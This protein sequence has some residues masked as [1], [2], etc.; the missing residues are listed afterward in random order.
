LNAYY[1]Q[2][3]DNSPVL[4]VMNDLPNKVSIAHANRKRPVDFSTESRTLASLSRSAPAYAGPTWEDTDGSAVMGKVVGDAPGATAKDI[5]WLKLDVVSRR[6]NGL[7]ADVSTVQRINTHGGV[8]R[9]ACHQPARFVVSHIPPIMSSCTRAADPQLPRR[10]TVDTTALLLK[11]ATAV[12]GWRGSQGP[13][14][15]F[16]EVSLLDL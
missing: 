16:S 14:T 2:S 10:L 11:A 3:C 7:L 9:G 12:V 15:D 8:I 13:G 4:F 1:K 6:G 5:S